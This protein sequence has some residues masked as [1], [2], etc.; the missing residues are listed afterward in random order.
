MVAHI[1]KDEI[2]EF[3][4]LEDLR[5]AAKSPFGIFEQRFALCPR[6]QIL[7][8][9][10]SGADFRATPLD[11]HP[12]HLLFIIEEDISVTEPAL[13]IGQLVRLRRQ[14]AL[15]GGELPGVVADGNANGLG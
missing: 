1:L 8:L 2:P 9:E 10:Q 4:L 14:L 6:E 5:T 3:A 13:F 15:R 11:Q 7:R 12:P